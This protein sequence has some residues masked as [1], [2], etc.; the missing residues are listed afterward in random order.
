[1]H[2]Y[3]PA[4]KP[5]DLVWARKETLRETQAKVTSLEARRAVASRETRS[6]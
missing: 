5:A 4:P 2:E 6:D 3:V 1:V